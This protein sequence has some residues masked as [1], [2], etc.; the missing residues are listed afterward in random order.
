MLYHNSSS[1]AFSVLKGQFKNKMGDCIGRINAHCEF[2]REKEKNHMPF[3]T[4]I[5]T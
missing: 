2:P 4:F 1:E 5:L 3:S